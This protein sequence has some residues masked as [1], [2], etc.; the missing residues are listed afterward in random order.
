MSP[1]EYSALIRYLGRIEGLAQ[2][3]ED[4]NIQ[5][6]LILNVDRIFEILT[7]MVKHA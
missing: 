1:N 6:S 4:E 2:G 5:A 3:V 7:G